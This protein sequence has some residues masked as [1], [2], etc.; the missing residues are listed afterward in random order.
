VIWSLTLDEIKATGVGQRPQ[1]PF[2]G[3]RDFT[4][5]DL[6]AARASA[7]LSTILQPIKLDPLTVADD[8]NF[9]SIIAAQPNVPEVIRTRLAKLY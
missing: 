6:F 3:P 7:A 2:D 1:L 9:L 4:G 8:P 5:P